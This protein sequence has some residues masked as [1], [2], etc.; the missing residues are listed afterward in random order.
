MP[1]RKRKERDV[2]RVLRYALALKLSLLPQELN[3]LEVLSAFRGPKPRRDIDNELVL[4][5]FSSMYTV[6]GRTFE[7]K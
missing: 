3:F 2:E 5:N 7:Q 4:S 6:V 1:P